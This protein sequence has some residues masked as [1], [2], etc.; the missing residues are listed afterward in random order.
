MAITRIADIIVPQ[1]FNSYTLEKSV[2]LDTFVQSGIIENDA[3]LNSLASAGGKLI[4]M[5]G[6]KDL[7]GAD[8]VLSDSAALTPGNI[9]TQQDV[10]VLFMRGRAWG[11]NDL[12]K[13]LSGADPMATIGNLV[14][15]YWVRRRQALL[16]SELKGIFASGTLTANQLDVSALAGT[17]ATITGNTFIDALTKLGDASGKIGAIAI[18][19][20]VYAKLKKD[21]LITT[22]KPSENT[23]IDFYQGKRVIQDDSM[24][25]A[26]GVYTSYLFGQG[27]FGLGNGSPNIPTEID[28]DS[29][30]GEDYLINRSHFLLHPRGIQFTSSSVAGSSPTNAEVEI[31]ANW[32]KVW[33][34]KNIKIVEFK[35]KIV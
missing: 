22:I 6:F 18:H 8:E 15:A 13:S 33:D 20:S 25:A 24:P 11:T 29:L 12:A 35:H 7:T 14:A 19:S 17:A 5:P 16:I 21:N 28:R 31:G 27:A 23:E 4:N 34:S 32:S 3:Q 2:E 26:A 30:A 1:I 10:A 9:T